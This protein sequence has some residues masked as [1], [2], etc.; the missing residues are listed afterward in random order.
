MRPNPGV[1]IASQMTVRDYRVLD[2]S[3][4]IVSGAARRKYH[5][6]LS[7]RAYGLRSTWQVGFRSATGQ[8]CA[9]FSDLIVDDGLRPDRIRIASI[10]RLTPNPGSPVTTTDRGA[11]ASRSTI[12]SNAVCSVRWADS[13]PM[14]GPLTRYWVEVSL[15]ST[16]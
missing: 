12:A 15:V 16:A 4:L 10:N 9:G 7:R 5:V 3:N 13:R 11:S 1:R 14:I 8:I 6:G 2:D